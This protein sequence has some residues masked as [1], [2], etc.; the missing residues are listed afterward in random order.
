MVYGDSALPRVSL[1]HMAEDSNTANLQVAA[2]ITGETSLSRLAP[3]AGCG[4]LP[5]VIPRAAYR[6]ACG[7]DSGFPKGGALPL[8]ARGYTKGHLQRQAVPGSRTAGGE[9][10]FSQRG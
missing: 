5:G 1:V 10:G 7:R 6:S 2:E 3:D 4:S 8:Y 9:D